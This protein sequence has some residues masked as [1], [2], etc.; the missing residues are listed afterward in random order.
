MP[1]RRK[2]IREIEIQA[3]AA[4]GKALTRYE[5]RV[6]FVP[7]AIPGDVVD[8][9]V[10]LKSRKYLEGKIIRMHKP[11]PDRVPPVCEHLSLIHI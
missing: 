10:T 6:I 5:N 9:S 3:I 1:I 4:E 7:W 8:L 2:E 11:S